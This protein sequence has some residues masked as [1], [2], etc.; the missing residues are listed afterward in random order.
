MNKKISVLV[1]AFNDLSYIKNL[2]NTFPST[3]DNNLELII[4]DDSDNNLIKDYISTLN[5]SLKFVYIKNSCNKGAVANWNELLNLAN[6]DFIWL[7]HQN[8]IPDNFDLIFDEINNTD[9]I[10]AFIITTNVESKYFRLLNTVHKHTNK[11]L[12][13]LIL[14]N[15]RY[16][17]KL[18]V[19]GPPSSLILKQ[20]FYQSFDYSIEWLVDVEN[21]YRTFNTEIRYKLLENCIITSKFNPNSITS[22]LNNINQITRNEIKSIKAKHQLRFKI[23]DI[24]TILCLKILH[25]LLTISTIRIK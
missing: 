12:L 6:G 14:K 18:N 4:L 22:K 24:I 2:L 7:L 15:P 17:L 8:D 25:K 11:V 19:I 16:L 10:D 3:N 5:N 1:P 13:D 23:L 9:N 21:Y 20:E